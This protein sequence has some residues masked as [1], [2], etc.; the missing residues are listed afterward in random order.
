MNRDNL[1]IEAHR[2]SDDPAL[3]LFRLLETGP[4]LGDADVY[5]L[6]KGIKYYAMPNETLRGHPQRTVIEDLNSYLATHDEESC[7]SESYMCKYIYFATSFVHIWLLGQTVHLR[8]PILG[9]GLPN[10]ALPHIWFNAREETGDL[11]LVKHTMPVTA[12]PLRVTQYLISPRGM[13]TTHLAFDL[14]TNQSVVSTTRHVS[15]QLAVRLDQAS[16]QAPTRG[17]TTLARFILVLTFGRDYHLCHVYYNQPET[18]NIW[19]I[20]AALHAMNP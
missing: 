13:T 4:P 6:V 20:Q 9:Y 8:H 17:H 10:E 11:V 16:V 12:E 7:S 14:A 3:A 5:E 19:E 18:K 15:L 2:S 1:L